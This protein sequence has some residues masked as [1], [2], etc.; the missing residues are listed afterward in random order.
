MCQL[1]PLS[2]SAVSSSRRLALSGLDSPV[3]SKLSRT[4]RM[5]AAAISSIWLWPVAL[6]I[7]A[8]P[9]ARAGPS[10]F[11]ASRV[12]AIN[13]RLHDHNAVEMQL[14][15]QSEQVLGGGL[16]RR[17]DP[18]AEIGK[19]CG[20]EYVHVAV[21]GAARYVEIDRRV[22]GACSRGMSPS[23]PQREQ[24]AGPGAG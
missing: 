3:V 7:T 11:M 17:V 16:G 24:C 8:T 4:P 19:P 14:L 13:A 1:R 15:L 5:P 20:I 6:S 22:D 12:Q 10:F 23:A 21:A 9:R 18:P 2:C